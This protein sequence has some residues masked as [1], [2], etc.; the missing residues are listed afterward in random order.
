MP[1]VR[2]A[3]VLLSAA[4]IVLPG[5]AGP[6]V[7]EEAPSGV[8]L[9]GAWKLDHGASDDPQKILDHMRAEALKI[10]GHPPQQVRQAGAGTKHGSGRRGGLHAARS[11]RA[12]RR[13]TATLAHGAPHHEQR[14][15][16]R[17]SHRAAEPG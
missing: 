11:R 8:N 16:R 4:A 9:A 17:F 14:G 13:S 2:A 10:L 15:A 1:T 7:A 3:G 6:R 5:C 12:A